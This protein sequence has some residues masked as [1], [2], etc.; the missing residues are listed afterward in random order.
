MAGVL[1]DRYY[2]GQNDLLNL[3]KA[4][5]KRSNG[6][7]NLSITNM[8]NGIAPKIQAGSYIQGYE[9][10][11]YFEDDTD[12]TPPPLT[13]FDEPWIGWLIEDSGLCTAAFEFDGG[14][15]VWNP[16]KNGYYMNSTFRAFCKCYYIYN[17]GEYIL[18]RIL[19]KELY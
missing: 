14:Q 8:N 3:I 19:D 5:V 15:Y 18:K 7:F 17:T 9:G 2:F 6:F 10:I 4:N 1:I 16:F 13:G 11:Y 12:I